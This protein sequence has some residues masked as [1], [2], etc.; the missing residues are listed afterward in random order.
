MT[1]RVDFSANA[2]IYDRRHGASLA[3]D[4][5]RELA[6]IGRLPP[7]G[8][9]LD[10]GAGTGRVAI[11]FATLGYK[12]VALEPALPMLNELRSKAPD[13]TMHAVAGEAERL[14]FSVHSFD[15]VILAR[16]L[17]LMY[18]WQAVLREANAILKPGGCL[19]HEWGNGESDEE[20][21]QIRERL[22]TLFEE[23]G[24]KSPFHPGARSESEVDDFLVKLG[25]RRASELRTGPGPSTTL[26]KF[27]E[28]IVTGEFS[29]IWNVPKAAQESCLP[30]L[31][32][33]ADNTFDLEQCVPTPRQ[34]RWTI[35]HKK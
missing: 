22:R 18:D 25:L 3:L 7:G 9:A 14:P 32:D 4:I 17:Y 29:Y 19:F 2:S 11:A 35:Y 8:S 28:K 21:V 31:Q 27:V 20:W 34:L 30:R 13:S 1:Q 23:A 12:P 16:V 15:G 24:V 10:I 33:W 26:R 5:A 6:S